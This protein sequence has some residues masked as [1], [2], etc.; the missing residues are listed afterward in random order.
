MN[1]NGTISVDW[2]LREGNGDWAPWMR[3]TFART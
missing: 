2:W 1:A 3:N